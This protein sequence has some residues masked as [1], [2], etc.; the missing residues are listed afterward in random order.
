M[1]TTYTAGEYGTFQAG[2]TQSTF[3]A[4]SGYRYR[5]GYNVDLADMVNLGLYQ[6]TDRGRLW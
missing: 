5:F 2:A 1:G 3:D 6:R 4:A